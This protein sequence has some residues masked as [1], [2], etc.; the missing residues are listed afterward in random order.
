M[1]A[2]GLPRERTAEVCAVN[3]PACL[4]RERTIDPPVNAPA[5]SAP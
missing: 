1:P 3:A 4:A 5:T 2:R